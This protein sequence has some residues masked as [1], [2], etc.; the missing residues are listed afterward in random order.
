[1]KGFMVIARR[2]QYF[3]VV[4]LWCSALTSFLDRLSHG[5]RHDTPPRAPIFDSPGIPHLVAMRTKTCRLW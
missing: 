4:S 5:C 2:S 1:M 3:P